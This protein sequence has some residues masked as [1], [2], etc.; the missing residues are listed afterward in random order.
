[1][2]LIKNLLGIASFIG[3]SFYQVFILKLILL[4]LFLLHSVLFHLIKD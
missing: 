1:M 2:E 4:V 3:M